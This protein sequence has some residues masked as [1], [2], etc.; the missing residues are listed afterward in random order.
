MKCVIV[1]LCERESSMHYDEFVLPV[2]NVV[3]KICEFEVIHYKDLSEEKVNEFDKVILCG[4]ALIDYE[5]LENLEKFDWIKNT[6]KHIL[7][8]CSGMQVIGKI[9]NCDLID[10]QD[11]GISK[12][13]S[14]GPNNLTIKP[15]FEI[16]NLHNKAVKVNNEFEILFEKEE[17]AQGI[18]HKQ[19]EIYGV[20]FHPEVRNHDLI[21]NFLNLKF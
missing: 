1:N 12:I 15:M 5:Y 11:I 3:K 2:I 4:T 7:G 6:S 16:Y 14:S 21:E 20:L 19:K 13:R 18:K 9:F 10:S 8:I 17:I